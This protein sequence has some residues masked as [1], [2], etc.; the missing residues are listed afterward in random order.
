MMEAATRHL[1]VGE[2][3]ATLRF[4][5]LDWNQHGLADEPF[6]ATFCSVS[7]AR[8][9]TRG[10]P[11]DARRGV[12]HTPGGERRGITVCKVSQGGRGTSGSSNA[13]QQQ[14]PPP[15]HIQVGKRAPS[16][17]MAFLPKST[18]DPACVIINHGVGRP[19]IFSKCSISAGLIRF[20]LGRD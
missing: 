1:R 3:R 20:L 7:S 11:A 6:S 17:N 14:P 4:K 16:G 10:A 13:Q 19:E 2:V 15:T 5:K 8:R 18:R 12:G 9:S